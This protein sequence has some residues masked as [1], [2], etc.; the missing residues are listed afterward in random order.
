M[1]EKIRTLEIKSH[2]GINDV[3][4]GMSPEEVEERMGKANKISEVIAATDDGEFGDCNRRKEVRG[5]TS[6]I[7]ENNELIC[8]SGELS[9][10]FS[11]HGGEIPYSMLESIRFLKSKSK[12]NMRF[13]GIM[14]YVFAD[15]GI[16]L[17][18]FTTIDIEAGTRFTETSQRLA[19]CNKSVLKRYF[20]NFVIQ[21]EAKEKSISSHL[22]ENLGRYIEEFDE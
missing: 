7:Y 22:I 17:Y 6:Y 12:I 20:N 5:K 15:L 10:S 19:V 18:P 21:Q 1:Q 16:V 2:R 3:T 9:A 4:F 8:I 14:S 13:V 11:L